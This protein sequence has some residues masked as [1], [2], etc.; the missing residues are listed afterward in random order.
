M[1]LLKYW[2]E[3][4]AELKE[5]QELAEAE[6]REISAA[7]QAVSEAPDNFFITTLTPAGA[8]R[9]EQMLELPVQEGGQIADRRFRI[10]T[11]ATEQRPFTFLRLKE[12]MTTL[13]GEDGFTVAMVGTYTLTVR[14][15]L[16][17]KQNYDDVDT[18]LSRIVPENLIIDLSLL[19]NQHVTLSAF[20]HAQLAAYS[21]YRLRNEVLP[22]GN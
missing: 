21:H 4:L 2:P 7:V 11:K 8:K 5:F 9:W 17:V 10:L 20:T 22:N 12:L 19:Y 6:Q 16:T 3:F 13:C 1:E 15:A 18:L 14:V